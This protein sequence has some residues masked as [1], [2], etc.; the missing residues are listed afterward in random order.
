M[1]S[2]ALATDYGALLGRRVGDARWNHEQLAHYTKGPADPRYLAL[3][4]RIAATLPPVLR[5][6]P[7]A[8]ALAIT[9]WL[10]HEGTY[11]LRSHHASAEDPTA[12]FLFGDKT[13][14]CVH[15]AHAATY[16]MRS[17]GLPARVATGY[18]IDESARAGGSA[19]LVTGDASHAWP[20]LYVEGVGW[21]VMDVAPERVLDPPPPPPDPDLQRLLG[22]LARGEAPL[23]LDG[24]G[25][26]PAVVAAV[27]RAASTLGLGVLALLGAAVSLMY[28]VK[29]WRRLAPLVVPARALPRV[30]YRAQLDR[31]AEA[32]L[33]RAPGETQEAFAERL[34]GTLPSFA[35][36]TWMHVGARFGSRRVP[37]RER[38]RAVARHAR[39]ELRSATPLWR[40]ALGWIEP[41]SWWTAR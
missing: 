20:E 21:V 40:R 32:R 12:S 24:R 11:S 38:V 19:L 5:D 17:P 39:A 37:T 30:A 22:E 16:L 8:K 35:E 14:Y 27:K 15:F 4:Q 6:D 3:A 41:W 25:P 2:A 28:I 26:P 18:A 33:W 7:V 29:A 9:Q 34:A 31:L 13:G 1:K 36:L 10:G 23:P